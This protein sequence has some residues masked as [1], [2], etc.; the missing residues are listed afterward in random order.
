LKNICIL[1][2][3][4][5]FGVVEAFGRM[6]AEGLRGN[7]AEVV[8]IDVSS[9]DAAGRLKA[10][11]ATDRIDLVLAM[12]PSPL[13]VRLNGRK[14]FSRIKAR[15]GI[16]LLDN[17][18]YL[19]R[20]IESLLPEMPDG[21]V[22]LTVDAQQCRQ[23]RRHLDRLQRGGLST[24]FLPY[25]G[26]PSMP[27]PRPGSLA[28]TFDLAVFATLDQQI[29][30]EFRRGDDDRGTLPRIAHPLPAERVAEAERR[31]QAMVETG[32]G[33]DPVETIADVL[34]TDDVMSDP[35]HLAFAQVFDSYLKRY[36]RLAVM[37]ALMADERSRGMRL[38]IVGTGWDRLG[39]LPA[40]W[41]FL[42]PTHYD[43][44]F[45]LFR[46]SCFVLNTD[47]NWTHGVHDRVF[48]AMAALCVPVTNWNPYADIHL[49]DGR[50]SILYR[51][52][53][54]IP[55][56]LAAS[57]ADWAGMAECGLEAFRVNFTW[58]DRS[59]PLLNWLDAR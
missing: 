42:G 12:N 30:A 27:L 52:A 51:S 41:K 37:R 38:A 32:Y 16:L 13:K 45:E 8:V 14:L 34:G 44:Q 7:G 20:E 59:R 6:I 50:D 15:F 10:L 11:S 3:Q 48:N 36:R 18:I 29:S 22:F 26:R 28:K 33:L 25:G 43:R 58:R 56:R 17:P 21:S 9:K 1:V 55:E 39:E 24:L 31:A 5:P 23:L 4:H 53:G 40:S 47:P 2:N 46:R 19:I 57:L 49:A 54:E 35:A